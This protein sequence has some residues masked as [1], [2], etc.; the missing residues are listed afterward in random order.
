MSGVT[1]GSD[2]GSGLGGNDGNC[3]GAKDGG[4]VGSGLGGS[5]GSGD[6]RGVGTDDGAGVGSGVGDGVGRGVGVLLGKSEGVA[7]GRGEGTGV[8]TGVGKKVGLV[9][10]TSRISTSSVEDSHLGRPS[11]RPFL[12][13]A[14]SFAL[15]SMGESPPC[16]CVW[17]EAVQNVSSV[18]S[19]NESAPNE[20]KASLGRRLHLP[21]PTARRG[22]RESCA[23]G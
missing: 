18:G 21:R 5:V 2:V 7:V 23:P 12:K 13:M 9:T 6:G 22:F 19:G 14:R 20:C 8:G 15:K 3:E 1:D 11:S 16:L 4:S 17:R 10:A